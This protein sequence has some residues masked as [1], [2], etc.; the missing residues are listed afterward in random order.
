M[1]AIRKSIDQDLTTDVAF[2]FTSSSGNG[3]IGEMGNSER[4]ID[5]RVLLDV[6]YKSLKHDEA[7]NEQIIFNRFF[8]DI[9]LF[10]EIHKI[11][12]MNRISSIS[13]S[14]SAS[15]FILISRQTVLLLSKSRISS[16]S[17]TLIS[18]RTCNSS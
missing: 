15:C 10:D 1:T 16:I 12:N 8:F 4:S 17:A 5:T 7:D 14:F 3:K 2:L 6:K 11:L 18:S 13:T 9:A